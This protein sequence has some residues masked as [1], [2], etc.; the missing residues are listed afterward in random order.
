LSAISSSRARC[1]ASSVPLSA[2]STSIRSIRPSR[3]SHSAQSVAWIL[4]WER[5][6]S[7]A[8]SGHCL[9]RAYID[10]VIDLQEPSAISR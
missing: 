4:L 1:S 3:V 9:R 2:S 5:R 7:T 8:V 6:T 10:T